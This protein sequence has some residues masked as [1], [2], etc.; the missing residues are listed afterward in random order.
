MAEA[1]ARRV[2]PSEEEEFTTLLALLEARSQFMAW[3]SDILCSEEDGVSGQRDESVQ[4]M[5]E[6][7]AQ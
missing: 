3:L 7:H 5:Q 1:V 2:R 6:C 4:S